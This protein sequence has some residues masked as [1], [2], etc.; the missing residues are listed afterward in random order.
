MAD[1]AVKRFSAMLISLPFRGL[2]VLP[3]GTITQ[4]VRQAAMYYYRGILWTT[5]VVV[6]GPYRVGIGVVSVPGGNVGHVYPLGAG[7][8]VVSVPGGQS[9]GVDP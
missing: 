8:G 3:D 5:S 2:C 1:A 7:A 9:G 6:A 4:A